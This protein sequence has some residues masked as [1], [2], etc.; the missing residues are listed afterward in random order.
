MNY[1]KKF[2]NDI[3]D[4]F[5]PVTSAATTL[6]RIVIV[7]GPNPL[8]GRRVVI[9]VLF[10][11]DN[12]KHSFYMEHDPFIWVLLLIVIKFEQSNASR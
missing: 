9:S 11:S 7:S 1:L 3:N 8:L 10:S 2:C 4:K 5:E 12:P 6:T